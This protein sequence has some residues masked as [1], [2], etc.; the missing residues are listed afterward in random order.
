M[1]FW[2]FRP[3]KGNRGGPSTLVIFCYHLIQI[4]REPR[5]HG[6][7]NRCGLIL[8]VSLIPFFAFRNLSRELGADRLKAML[9]ETVSPANK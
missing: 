7:I 9:F 8:F 4:N 1:Q 5:R 6:I 2:K 3:N